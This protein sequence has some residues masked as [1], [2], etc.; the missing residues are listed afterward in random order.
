MNNIWNKPLKD[1]IK[2]GDR[3]KWTPA[4]FDGRTYIAD[5]TRIVEVTKVNRV[6]FQAKIVYPKA[7]ANGDKY[8]FTHLDIRKNLMPR[9]IQREILEEIT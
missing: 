3:L 2:I 7:K 5:T 8:N 9:V 6:T 1:L 4:Y